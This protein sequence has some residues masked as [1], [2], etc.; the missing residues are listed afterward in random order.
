MRN[1]RLVVESEEKFFIIFCDLS[2]D[3]KVIIGL[4]RVKYI[5]VLFNNFGNIED[6][7]TDSQ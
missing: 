1:A 7:M 2:Q 5:G 4:E 6:E 3:G